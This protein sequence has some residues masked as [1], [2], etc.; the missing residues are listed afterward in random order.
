MSDHSD[1]GQ[2]RGPRGPGKQAGGRQGAHKQ[3]GG[4]QGGSTR[5]GGA[6][7]GGQS[8]G[9]KGRSVSSAGRQGRAGNPGAGRQG[10]GRSTNRQS[11][12]TARP[13]R[14]PDARSVALAVMTAV[15]ERA[16]YANLQLP[17][18]LHRA[19]LDTRDAALATEL[20]YG[21]LR[22]QGLL[23][24]IIAEASGRPVEEIDPP[25][26]D[27]VR[28]GA[29]QLL[30]TRIGAHAAV[31]TSVEAARTAGL[32]RAGAFVNAVL[33]KVAAQDLEAWVAILR[34]GVTDPV[35]RLAVGTA[36]PEWI[37][38]A[39]AESLGADAA[40]LPELLAADDARPKVHLAA[41]PG[42]IS[43]EELALIT[44]GTEGT[45]SPYAVHLDSG[46]P[47]TMEP[48]KDRLATVQDEGS[49]VVA[50]ALSRAPLVGEDGGRWLDLCAGP[51]GKAVMLGALAESEGATVT[52]IEISEHRT[53]LV[54]AA[55]KG[56]PVKVH[57]ADGRDPGL[58]PGFD[59]VLVDAPCS[60]LGAL[61]RRPEA[62]WR[63][64]P[65]DIQG[66]VVLQRA[67]LDSA[68][69]LVRPGG[70]VLYATCSPHLSETV[71][72]IR[73]AARRP[74][75]VLLDVREF[76]TGAD[77]TPIEGLGDGPWV[78]LWP[79]RHGTDAMFMAAIRRSDDA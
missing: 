50:V 11:G 44:G 40:E 7:G 37:A 49:Q 15:R 4:G 5:G 12:Q 17:T 32:G 33:R 48:I 63:K 73:E 29:Y 9:G 28:L 19:R 3:G 8:G 57:T 59:R 13:L 47:G 34:E 38:R 75:V 70:V 69:R 51:G 23:D 18:E 65:A 42:E 60:G 14:Q 52:G 35:V 46:D 79:H 77:G 6:S 39:F 25:V 1:Q 21:T 31:D 58:E 74:D 20:T 62:R 67:L 36:H 10:A 56:L 54:R 66:L 68:L 22:A 71:S 64:T 43:A 16:A 26:L 24:R 76:L 30:Y 27:L 78:Q 55:T 53:D 2:G 72:V 61:R 45:L 41:R